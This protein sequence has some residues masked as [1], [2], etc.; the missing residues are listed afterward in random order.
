MLKRVL[1]VVSV[2]AAAVL[3]FAVYQWN[4]R[5]PARV[6][7]TTAPVTT[8]PM[9]EPAPVGAARLNIRGIEVP[10]GRTPAVRVFNARGRE[11]IRFQSEEWRPI[12]E[13][14]W[15]MTRLEARVLLPGTQLIYVTADQ[16]QVVVAREDND[17]YEPKRGRLWGKVH[18]IVDQTDDRWRAQHP[19]R[20]LPDQHEE[21][22]IHL[23]VDE[24][25]FDLDV[26]RLETD[27]PLRLESRDATVEGTGLRLAWNEVERRIELLEI[28]K[29]RRM[30]LRRNTEFVEFAMP[31]ADRPRR[32]RPTTQPA[33]TAEPPPVV[34]AAAPAAAPTTAE[35][36][37]VGERIFLNLSDDKRVR[38]RP[39]EMTTYLA[40]FEGG[41]T[42]RQMRGEALVGELAADAL[43][44]L[45]DFGERQREAT[46]WSPGRR[47]SGTAS[48]PATAPAS[49]Q[50]AVEQGRIELAWTGRL[51]MTPQ[52]AAKEEQTGERLQAVATGHVQ[53]KRGD[54]GAACDKLVFRNESEQAEL[55]GSPAKLFEGATRSIEGE[56]IFYDRREGL[57][58]I[59]GPGR[60]VDTRGLG[61]ALDLPG[62]ADR[63]DAP[64]AGLT[65]EP[66]VAKWSRRVVLTFATL[67]QTRIDPQTGE[68]TTSQKEYIRHARFSGDVDLSRGKQ[69]MQADDIELVFA[70]PKT[71]AGPDRP[72]PESV[73]TPTGQL[74]RM[75]A[76]GKVNFR[77]LNQRA[78][79]DQGTV[80]ADELVVTMGVDA[81][82]KAMPVRADARGNVSAV[83]ED[84]LIKATDRLAVQFASLP[85]PL[86]PIDRAAAAPVA[87]ARGL[88]PATIDWDALD[89]KRRNNRA[90][91]IV[92]LEAF[93][94]V[95]ARDPSEPLDLSAAEL[96]CWMPEGRQKFERAELTGSAQREAEVEQ[97]GYYVRGPKIAIN[98]KTQY[99]E[100]P[101]AGLLRFLSKEDLDGRR[102]EQPVPVTVSWSKRMILDGSRNFGL[103]AGD[104]HAVSR[105]TV[106]DCQEL[107]LTFEDIP[108]AEAP[109]ATTTSPADRYWLLGPVVNRVQSIRTKDREGGD[110]GMRK[111]AVHLLA[112]EDARVTSTTVDPKEPSRILSRMHIDGPE[113]AVDLVGS[114]LTVNGPGNLLIE[115]YR[116]PTDGKR[117][118][119]PVV[120]AAPNPF[121]AS[122]EMDGPSRTAFRWQNAM[123]F[124]AQRNLAVLDREVLMVH[125]S[126]SE[127][128]L[129]PQEAAAMKID[130][131]KLQTAKGRRASLRADNLVVQFL[132]D[133]SAPRKAN[134]PTP[135]AGATELSYLCATGNARLEEGTRSVHGEVITY[136]RTGNLVRV[137]RSADAPAKFIDLDE[138]TG[139][140]NIASGDSLTYNV[141]TGQLEGKRFQASA[142][143]R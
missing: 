112:K 68:T 16:G 84:R 11:K 31:G 130:V 20:A 59:E 52:P 28:L 17:N 114:Q 29:G 118:E 125:L 70:D 30:E 41:V 36:P 14:E 105:N 102:L 104:V 25:R 62:G 97:R 43:D 3:L 45:F 27:G 48:A 95:E 6:V 51:A 141:E 15:H 103:F 127:L 76:R 42:I 49:T 121:G 94:D 46:E 57:A 1:L 111:R 78:Q 116:M 131:E 129:S 117:R 123:S 50:P 88:D 122:L 64:T 67:L 8:L 33:R 140:Y 55:Y 39:A 9:A 4:E 108:A 23:W 63:R 119:R 10:P 136:N 109:A 96:K 86:P 40:K 37:T 58:R 134:D 120:Q 19:D 18:L 106:L 115:D 99:A 47:E 138:R 32:P 75:I 113:L 2:F 82:G 44:V 72:A 13:T 132:R 79:G 126:G 139:T 92:Y 24:V 124:F 35:A 53:V 26:S 135:L 60:M 7:V 5:T 89:E 128:K 74:D 22:L 98:A 71:A 12:S 66:V 91:E 69:A 107:A 65:A 85:A 38:A 77:N 34:A 100:V 61:Q 101:S 87:R 93:G 21:F 90:V 80:T 137:T 81:D 73:R 142:T 54:A 56:R 110:L 83:Q 143:G 133:T